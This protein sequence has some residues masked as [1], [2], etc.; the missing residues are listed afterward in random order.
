[1]KIQYRLSGLS[2]LSLTAVLVLAGCMTG[3]DQGAESRVNA[4]KLKF[5]NATTTALAQTLATQPPAGAGQPPKVDFAALGC[6]KLGKVMEDLQS[7]TGNGLPESFKEFLGCFGIDGSGSVN[8][9]DEITRKIQEEL[10]AIL[11]CACGSSALSDM[12]LA[13]EYK[14]FSV[15]ASA[16]AETYSAATASAAAAYTA[17]GSASGS[18]YTSSGSAAGTYKSK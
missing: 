16:A 4:E 3:Q 17:S 7:N 8:D 10:P 18:D 14:L 13:Q 15:Q 11:D 12:F 6:P 2:A 1:M 9:I 5:V